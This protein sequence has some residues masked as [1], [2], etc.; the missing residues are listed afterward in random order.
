MTNP[1]LSPDLRAQLLAAPETLLDDPEMMRA[2]MAA[3]EAARGS[4]VID[5]RGRFMARLEERLD[6]LETTHRHVLAAAYDTV[7][8]TRLIHRAALALVR[9]RDLPALLEALAGEVP[10]ILRIESVRLLVE[11][12]AP[13]VLAAHPHL[14]ETGPAGAVAARLAARRADGNGVTLRRTGGP[15]AARAHPHAA[16]PI[17]SEAVMPL[18]LTGGPALILLGAADAAS[19]APGQ[20]TDLLSFLQEVAAACLSRWL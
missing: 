12:A 2:L 9:A 20:G 14:I 18:A 11:G 13:E 15:E 8:G 5:I 6:G 4:N 10:M 7:A 17:A 1:T 3:D 19:F 16:A